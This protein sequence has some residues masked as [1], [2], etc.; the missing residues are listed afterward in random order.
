[1]STGRPALV[2][3]GTGHVGHAI[4]RELLARGYRVDA[5]SRKARPPI[6][7][8]LDVRV[9]QGDASVP[10]DIEAHIEQGGVVVDAAAPYPLHLDLSRRDGVDPVRAAVARTER[11]VEATER[12]GATLVFISS[13][14]T[15]PRPAGF[16][17]ELE[18]RMRRAAHPYFVTKQAME[19][20][21]L[22]GCRRG[23]RAVVVN[24]TACLGPWDAKPRSLCY[25]PLLLSGELPATA[26]RAVN[27][28]DVRDVACGAVAALEANLFARPLLLAGHDIR[29]DHLSARACQLA[30][31]RPPIL[32]ASTR[33]TATAFYWTEWF[34]EAMG[35]RAPFPSLP[36]LLLCEARATG[37]GDA[38]RTLGVLPRPLEETLVDSIEW[39][40]QLGY[41]TT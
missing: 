32:R 14:T 20:V 15:L 3:G 8:G 9:R 34:F 29:A 23:L 17:S 11:L 1:V 10:G 13:F 7:E 4:L 30:G 40:R 2:L 19:G 6:L 21:V 36:A 12:R 33:A 26:M 27:V 39:Y 22:E 31:R 18:A 16:V 5:L 41:L 25:L 35:R 38:Q 24:P 28:V 37:I